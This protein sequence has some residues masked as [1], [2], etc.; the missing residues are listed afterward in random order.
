M[1]IALIADIHAN[2]PALAAV[3]EDIR[4]IGVDQRVCLGDAATLGCRP[5]EVLGTIRDLN[6]P[7]IMGNHD[8]FLNDPDLIGRYTEAPA[9]I[10]A[11]NWCR[12]RLS[13]E[14][15]AFLASFRPHL[16]MD[17]G[18]GARLFLFHGS[19]RSHMENILADTPAER[20]DEMLDGRR[21]EVMAGGHTHVQ[22][23]RRHDGLLL[24]NAG[25]VGLPFRRFVNGGP[26]ELLHHAEYAIV[27][28]S[29]GR[30][31]VTLR[32]VPV[33]ID[34]LVASSKDCDNPFRIYL[35]E[36]YARG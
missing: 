4:K 18:G 16:E 29:N 2:E 10:E 21:A 30:I 1:R 36:Q 27:E 26:P 17:L 23:L 3:L 33:D 24:V 15:R 8:A 19:P 32:R 14:D 9:V 28:A 11:V 6:I 12:S 34:A 5:G 7:C 20:L 35:L 13:A 22:M 25:S 31:A